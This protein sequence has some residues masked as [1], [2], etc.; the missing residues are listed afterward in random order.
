MKVK[1]KGNA[2][3]S[4]LSSPSSS[5][6]DADSLLKLLPVTIL[7]L[8]FSLPNQDREVLAYL[9]S[10]SMNGSNQSY[11]GKSKCRS[12]KK[13]GAFECGCFECYTSFWYR[14][15]LSPNRELIHRVIEE[16]EEHLVVNE[17]PRKQ[18][19]GGKKKGSKKV[20]VIKLADE[21]D[22]AE[23]LPAVE[24]E[25]VMMRQEKTEGLVMEEH[26]EEK[27]G[28]GDVLE[29]EVVTVQ[30]AMGLGASYHKG[31]ARKVLPDVVGLLNSRLWSLWSPGI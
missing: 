30:A 9:I 17:S 29:M 28:S 22:S 21:K 26:E 1:R 16:F 8:A 25:V 24:D 13:M 6:K 5:F 7:A 3:S 15:D 18:N 2:L 4:P 11:H 12:V 23:I 10:R 19:R 14:W 20:D 27:I 31:F